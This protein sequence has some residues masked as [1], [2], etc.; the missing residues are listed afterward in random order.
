MVAGVGLGSPRR[1][2]SIVTT[3]E[4]LSGIWPGVRTRLNVTDPVPS[5]RMPPGGVVRRHEGGVGRSLGAKLMKMLV[6]PSPAAVLV[7]TQS[8]KPKVVK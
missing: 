1:L 7:T 3:C 6:S 4:V 2:V 5:L 8:V